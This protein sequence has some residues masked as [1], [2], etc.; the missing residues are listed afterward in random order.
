MYDCY[1]DGIAAERREAFPLSWIV[2]EN[3]FYLSMWVIAGWL[4]WPIQWSTWPVATI[5]WTTIVVIVQVLLKKHNCSGCYYYGKSCHLGWGKISG[6]LF[7]QDS[8]DPKIGLRLSLFY[9]LSPPIILVMAI[10]VGIFLEVDTSHWI[11]L[12]AFV[13]LNA[14]AFPVRIKG[15]GLCAMREVCP[16][17]AS[18][19]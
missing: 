7:E 4:L 8:G 16:G 6:W 15:C 11:L 10:L 2:S 18:K 5:A 17:T 13:A 1:R 14:L 3:L 19:S 12:G 9:V